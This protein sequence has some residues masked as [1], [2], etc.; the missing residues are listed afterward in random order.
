MHK[1]AWQ[2]GCA[3]NQMS[4]YLFHTSNIPIQPLF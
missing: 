3:I 2:L 1:K 4:T